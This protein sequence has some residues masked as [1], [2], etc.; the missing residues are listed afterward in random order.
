[1]KRHDEASEKMG[2]PCYVSELVPEGQLIILTAGYDPPLFQLT[3]LRMLDERDKE[4][5]KEGDQIIVGRQA[6]ID[7]TEEI[8]REIQDASNRLAETFVMKEEIRPRW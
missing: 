6:D 4:G 5:L 3:L 1:M 2:V 7:R 8:A